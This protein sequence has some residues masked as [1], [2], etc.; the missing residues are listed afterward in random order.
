MIYVLTAV[1]IA[2]LVTIV[3]LTL[4]ANCSHDNSEWRDCGMFYEK[5]CDRCFG[6]TV[7]EK[8]KSVVLHES[9]LYRATKGSCEDCVWNQCSLECVMFCDRYKHV[10]RSGAS[11]FV[12]IV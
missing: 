8:S 4:S 11:R 5:T 6:G 10:C 7:V 3:S 12:E 9:K 1:G 2:V